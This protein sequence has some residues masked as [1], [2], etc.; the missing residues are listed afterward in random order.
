MPGSNNPD[1][2]NVKSPVRKVFA[3]G[4]TT[5]FV[6]VSLVA[7]GDDE[8]STIPLSEWV[9]EFD[10][11]CLELLAEAQSDPD[12]TEGEFETLLDAVVAEG[13]SITPPDEMAD[14]RRN[15]SICSMR[16]RT[17]MVNTMRM[18]SACSSPSR[19]L[20]SPTSASPETTVDP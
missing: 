3:A 8:P 10:K 20:A 14:V 15:F 13:R 9:D 5:L 1:S 6:V 2:S 16:T 11:I 7:C 4:F 12:L 19:H 18:K 17:A